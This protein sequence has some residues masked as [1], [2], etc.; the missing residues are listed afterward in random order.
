MTAGV[1]HGLRRWIRRL[2]IGLL[3]ACAILLLGA[4]IALFGAHFLGGVQGWESWLSQRRILLLGWRL[5]VYVAA[6]AG[7]CWMRKRLLMRE[8]SIAARSRLRRTELAAV[9]VITALECTT[10]LSRR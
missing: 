8:S 4:S 6:L 7:W 5:L 1:Q 10:W 3:W 9:I 2:S